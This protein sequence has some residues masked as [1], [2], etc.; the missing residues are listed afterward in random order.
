MKPLKT[1]ILKHF[2]ATP[3]IRKRMAAMS[4]WASIAAVLLG[5]PALTSA[6]ASPSLAVEDLT[7]PSAVQ[8]S[9][10]HL[11]PIKD[12][13]LI[14]SWV[15]PAKESGKTLKFSIY[16][17]GKWSEPRSVVSLADIYDLPKVVALTDGAF[18]AVWGTETKV[19]ADSSSEVYVSRSA[20]GGQTWSKP[21]QANSDKTVKT[22]RYNAYIAPLDG[23]KTAIFW[24]DA[25]NHN[26]PKGTQIQY[27]MG[28]VMNTD[29]TVGP[30]FAVDNDICSCCQLLP[31]RYK[32]KLYVT[33][34]DRLQGNVRDIAVIPWPGISEAKP[35]NVH[36]DNWVLEGC[37]GQNV[38]SAA[39]ANRLGVA[40]FTAAGG[41][42]KVQ[43]AFSD[44]PDKGF[45]KPINIDR[46]NNPQGEVKMAMLDDGHAAVQWLRTSKRGTSLQLAL[47]STDGKLLAERSLTKPNWKT[48]FKWPNLPTLAQAGDKAYF[49]W[50]DTQAGRIRLVKI[51]W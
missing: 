3:S 15:E 23:G 43:A 20:D 24:S 41:K 29:G 47:V 13:R 34:R 37:P 25:R 39:S 14:L 26:K 31:T 44:N 5:I 35:V 48:K 21:V 42:G 46:S 22:A 19:K 32:D 8:S 1:T 36:K 50:L 4:L 40:W 18:G 11:S 28:A 10:A 51:G 38:G 17:S 27:L 6:A 16:D 30:D 49:S 33:Y 12:G 2:I 9:Q 45:G 7:N